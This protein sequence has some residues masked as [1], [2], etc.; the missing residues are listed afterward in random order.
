MIVIQIL[1]FAIFCYA[2]LSEPHVSENKV[3]QEI[4]EDEMA[5]KKSICKCDN[6]NK[7]NH[8]IYEIRVGSKVIY[9]GR[10]NQGVKTRLT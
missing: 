8:S 9:I 7:R 1:V 2:I 4:L 6:D 10:T 3:Q 5:P